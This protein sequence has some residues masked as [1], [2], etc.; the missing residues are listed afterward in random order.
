[1]NLKNPKD[2]EAE[3][4]LEEEFENSNNDKPDDNVLFFDQQAFNEDLEDI[5]FDKIGVDDEDS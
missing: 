5:D 2:L 4:K 1:M 3:E